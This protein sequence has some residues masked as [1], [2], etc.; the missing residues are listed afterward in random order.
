VA[1]PFL[2]Y[3]LRRTYGI[4]PRKDKL[5]KSPAQRFIAMIEARAW[6]DRG[7]SAART[8]SP[9]EA[10]DV[11]SGPEATCATSPCSNGVVGEDWDGGRS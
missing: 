8:R 2:K 5:L 10:R 3:F 9:S 1:I 6:R 7:T 11:E 4:V